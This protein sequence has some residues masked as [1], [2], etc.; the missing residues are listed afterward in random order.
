MP[1]RGRAHSCWRFL[2]AIVKLIGGHQAA[3]VELRANQEQ[4]VLVYWVAGAIW[5]EEKDCFRWIVLETPSGFLTNCGEAH[6]I[7]EMAELCETD[8]TWL[9]GSSSDLA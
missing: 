9:H 3:P 4:V 8:R 5:P 2:E 1:F 7:E 6:V